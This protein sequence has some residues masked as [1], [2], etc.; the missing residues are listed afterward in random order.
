MLTIFT[1]L[2]V[3]LITGFLIL[4]YQATHQALTGDNDLGGIQ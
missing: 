1:S 3:A 4:R 2:I